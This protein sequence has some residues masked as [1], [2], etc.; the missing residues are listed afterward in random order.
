MSV[1][2]LPGRDSECPR[3]LVDDGDGRVAG[4]PLQVGDIGP[5]DACLVCEGF[6]AEALLEP[7]SA[8]VSGEALPD[9]HGAPETRLQTINLQTISD[10]R[11]DWAGAR[12]GTS[13]SL[14]VD[15][16][17]SVPEPDT[18]QNCCSD[19]QLTHDSSTREKVLEYRFLGELTTELMRRGV[20]FEVLRSD[21]DAWGADVVVHANR[22]FRHIQLKAMIE[23]GKR[24]DVT[25]NTRLAMSPSGCV[26]WMTYDP[27]SFA[28]KEFRWFGGRPGEPLPDL[29]STVARHSKANALGEKKVRPGHRVLRRSQF[30][31]V[32]TIAGLVTRL[33]GPVAPEQRGAL[34]LR[35]LAGQLRR[36]DAVLERIR[37]GDFTA[38]PGDLRW[39]QAGEI[40]ELIDGYEL[41]EQLGMGEPSQLEHR[42]RHDAELTSTWP[43]EALELWIALFLQFRR[44]RF[45][46]PFEPSPEAETLLDRLCAQL[47]DALTHPDSATAIGTSSTCP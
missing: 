18:A 33:F 40:A 7:E 20:A 46:S 47:R 25:I 43:G 30:E 16:T 39:N 38:L 35:H 12:S 6:L 34:L 4:T 19:A 1:E 11:L 3:Q 21:V 28:L 15:R 24:A 45:S 2:Q 5:V 10:I 9:I 8:Q 36:A 41:I 31:T 26:V 23:G 44:W 27:H 22:V 14:I 32:T 13:M 17:S 37:T 29:G 42:Q